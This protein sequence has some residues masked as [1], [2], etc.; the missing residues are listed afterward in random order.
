MKALTTA[1]I[2]LGVLAR[3]ANDLATSPRLPSYF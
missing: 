3:V 1:S 2:S